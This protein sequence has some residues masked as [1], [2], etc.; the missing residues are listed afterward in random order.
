MIGAISACVVVIVMIAAFVVYLKC[1]KS[2]KSDQLRHD[3]EQE[4]E[5]HEM[6]IRQM[7]REGTFQLVIIIYFT[8]RHTV[9]LLSVCMYAQYHCCQF[10]CMHNVTAVSLYVCTVSLLQVCMRVIWKVL[11]MAS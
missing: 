8:C 11:S 10:V 9:S 7:V 2:R 5:V 3:K 1:K 6:K 4:K